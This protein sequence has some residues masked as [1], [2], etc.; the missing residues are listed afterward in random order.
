VV[1]GRQT[2]PEIVRDTIKA[3]I[4]GAIALFLWFCLK[5]AIGFV[6]ACFCLWIFWYWFTNGGFKAFLAW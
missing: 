4:A 2:I 6:F 1:D 3:D 5:R